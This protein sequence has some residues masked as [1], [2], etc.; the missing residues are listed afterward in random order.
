MTAVKQLDNI[1]AVLQKALRQK[2]KVRLVYDS[3]YEKKLTVEDVLFREKQQLQEM[4]NRLC[5]HARRNELAEIVVFTTLKNSILDNKYKYFI[6]RRPREGSSVV[7]IKNN[8]KDEYKKELKVKNF[9][10]TGLT[11]EG[12]R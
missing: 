6:R 8:I 12:V 1:F 11:T 4:L 9:Y 10:F 2:K 5:N 7:M 3:V